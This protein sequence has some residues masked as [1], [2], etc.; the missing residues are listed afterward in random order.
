MAK[1]VKTLAADTNETTES[2]GEQVRAISSTVP[3]VVASISEI[4]D[5]FAT[6]SDHQNSIAG[7]IHEQ[8]DG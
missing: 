7:A 4:S 3:D 1:E 2:I 5:T 6:I 8:R